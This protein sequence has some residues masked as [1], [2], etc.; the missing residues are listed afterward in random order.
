MSII[1]HPLS[2]EKAIRLMGTS[3]DTYS[4]VNGKPGGFQ[5]YLLA[6]GQEGEPCSNCGKKI[7]R[8]KIGSRS[9]HYCP[10]CQKI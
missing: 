7:V 5:K 10:R 9:A 3:V 1:K 6:Y 2:T 4:G 8:K